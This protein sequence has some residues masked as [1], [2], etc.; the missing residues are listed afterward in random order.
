MIGQPLSLFA[1]NASRAY[2][3]RIAAELE[4]ALAPMRNATSRMA[5]TRLGRCRTSPAMMRS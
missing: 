5:S 1:L 4:V 3:E 2:A